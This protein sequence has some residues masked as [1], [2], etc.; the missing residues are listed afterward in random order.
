MA[1]GF[2]RQMVE[3]EKAGSFITSISSRNESVKKSGVKPSG[4]RDPPESPALHY[5]FP[6]LEALSALAET[7]QS[8]FSTGSRAGID[9]DEL[10]DATD[11]VK[12]YLR[13]RDRKFDRQKLNRELSGL[14]RNGGAQ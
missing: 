7:A 9:F 4:L 13:F 6:P 1:R 12:A 3:D 8:V 5:K 14:N 2:C 10:E 11:R